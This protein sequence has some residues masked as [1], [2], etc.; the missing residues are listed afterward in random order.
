MSYNQ[1]SV[2]EITSTTNENIKKWLDINYPDDV[3]KFTPKNIKDAILKLPKYLRDEN[4]NYLGTERLLLT[5]LF[6]YK[7]D[8]QQIKNNIDNAQKKDEPFLIS[9]ANYL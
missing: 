6:S 2:N 5:P 1:T 7:S 9:N 4:G 3:G 8:L